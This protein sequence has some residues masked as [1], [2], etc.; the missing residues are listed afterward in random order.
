MLRIYFILLVVLFFQVLFIV[1]STWQ[2]FTVKEL[3]RAI[4]CSHS[5]WADNAKA[6][7]PILMCIHLLSLCWDI[8][9]ATT[10]G[11]TQRWKQRV[12]CCCHALDMH[13]KG[14]LQLQSSLGD[15]L[16]LWWESCALHRFDDTFL[17]TRRHNT[18]SLIP[19]LI[20][21]II[22]PACFSLSERSFFILSSLWISEA[23][24]SFSVAVLLFLIH[25]TSYRVIEIYQHLR[26]KIWL[27]LAN[28]IVLVHFII[29]WNQKKNLN[30]N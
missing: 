28:L 24:E 11:L 29:L 22:N 8:W 23:L 21:V 20:D 16:S 6:W 27:I 5:N 14:P 17:L 26:L 15:I 12:V 13:W 7:F 10:C 25:R 4:E 3:F 19:L 2:R 9:R 30:Q 18:P 1:S